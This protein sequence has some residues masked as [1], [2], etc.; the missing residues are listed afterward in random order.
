M[1]VRSVMSAEGKTGSHEIRSRRIART[2][3]VLIT[4]G[5]IDIF[6]DMTCHDGSGEEI[7]LAY[8]KVWNAGITRAS[9][10]DNKTVKAVKSEKSPQQEQIPG[11]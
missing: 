2:V 3:I 10:R 4:A 6:A 8:A 7:R 9:H 11:I 1:K 5:K